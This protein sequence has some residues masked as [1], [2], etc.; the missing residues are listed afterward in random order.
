MS[1]D[2][3]CGIIGRV[4][5]TGHLPITSETDKRLVVFSDLDGTLLDH[6]TYD[7]QPAAS[8]LEELRRRCVP[9]VLV[10]SKTL[11]ELGEIR[12]AMA[13]PDPVVAEN[14]AAID[15]PDGYFADAPQPEVETIDRTTLQQHYASI[16]DD[17]GFDC[18][19]FFELGVDGIAA[20]TGLSR[21]QAEL[22][23]QRR[24]SEPILWRDT[25]ARLAAFDA[26]AAQHGLRTTR[27]GR[28]LHLTGPFDKGQAMRWLL[29]AFRRKWRGAGTISV[30]LGDGPNDLGMLAAADVA[31]V[32][33]GRHGQPMPLPGHSRVLRSDAAGPAGWAEAMR[34]VLDRYHA[35]TGETDCG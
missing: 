35:T 21:Q 11:A 27:G 10:S 19:A 13:L 12:Q 1:V 25:E 20:A 28:F 33:R 16:R 15:V 5:R 32:I 30:A 2:C 4:I 23:N 17:G 31:V 22:A 3:R 34:T 26:A 14:G 8:T 24:A 29:R 6:D 7:W 9:V 18:A